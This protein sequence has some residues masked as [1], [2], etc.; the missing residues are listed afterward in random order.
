MRRIKAAM[1]A[2][3]LYSALGSSA[4]ATSARYVTLDGLEKSLPTTPIVAG[5]DIDDTVLFSTPAYSY[6]ANNG[7]GPGGTNRYGADYLANPQFR[8]DL[9]QYLDKFS[10][11]KKAGEEL[12]AM[13]K[14]RGDTI[15]F[16]TKRNCYDDDAEV[17]Q[18]RMNKLFA[19]TSQVFCTNEQSKTPYLEKTGARIYYGDADTDIEYSMQVKGDKVRPIR[20]ERSRMSTN[21]G[22]YH[23]GKYG[24]EILADSE[25]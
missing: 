5:F 20:V 7:E 17:I 21:K 11:K 12:I 2:L 4:G 6:G 14:R 24:E 8:K 9:N 18:K 25:N 1:M 22:E 13:H 3:A 23:P 16:I 19:L 10:M 15:V